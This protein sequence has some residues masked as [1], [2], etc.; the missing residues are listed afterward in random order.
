M[1]IWGPVFGPQNPL[2]KFM[3]VTFLRPFPGNEAHQLFLGAQF[4]A[5]WVGGKKVYVEKVMCFF[6]PLVVTL[7]S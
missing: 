7:C 6:C 3:L 1:A 5:F 2:K 4:G